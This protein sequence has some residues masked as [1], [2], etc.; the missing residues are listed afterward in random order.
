MALSD[1]M[2]VFGATFLAFCQIWRPLD[3]DFVKN[4]SGNIFD[5]EVATLG[6]ILSQI[7]RLKDQSLP[8]YMALSD[9]M[10]G[11]EATFLAIRQ[12]WRPVRP[13]LWKKNF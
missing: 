4:N 9:S 12:K 3:P 5:H 8:F 10:L 11:S 13:Q 2:L 1:S 6:T 7:S